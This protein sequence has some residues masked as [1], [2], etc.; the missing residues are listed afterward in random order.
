[1]A[2]SSHSLTRAG[3]APAY[4]NGRGPNA[5]Q[6]LAW[7]PA[8][9]APGH[10]SVGLG[11]PGA[12]A[13][14]A[15]CSTDRGLLVASAPPSAGPRHCRIRSALAARKRWEQLDAGWFRALAARRRSEALEGRGARPPER[16]GS[17]RRP[18]GPGALPAGGVAP[19]D[20]CPTRLPCLL[21]AR[22]PRRM[23]GRCP[24]WEARPEAL[25]GGGAL[26][27]VEENRPRQDELG[28]TNCLPTSYRPQ[29][30]WLVLAHFD[31]DGLTIF[32]A[33]YIYH[34]CLNQYQCV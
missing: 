14:T 10:G 12:R 23:A 21:L 22:E 2:P 5:R 17:A 32:L 3:T 27:L 28:I 29:M 7:T 33:E 30:V 9:A 24:A 6:S 20:R 1:V 11:D 8:T 25:P 16:G 26:L 34:Y 31:L 18:V 15:G 4:R 19:E 13:R